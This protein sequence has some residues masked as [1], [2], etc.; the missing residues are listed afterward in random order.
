MIIHLPEEYYRRIITHSRKELPN[1]ACGLI[2]GVKQSEEEYRVT[3]VFEMRNIDATSDH[4]SMDPEEQFKVVKEIRKNGRELIGNYHSH[5]TTPSRPSREDIRLAY[6]QEL[7]YFIVS[8][9][10]DSP[11]LNAFK[12]KERSTVKKLIIKIEK[13]G[14][15][16]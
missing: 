1:E 4:F 15:D 16:E 2:E 9:I 14:Q 13:G 11:V 3:S 12:I 8:L 10:D 6:N 7:I 5:P